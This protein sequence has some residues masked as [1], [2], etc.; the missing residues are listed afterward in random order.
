MQR[1]AAYA[2]AENRIDAIVAES[3]KRGKVR[4]DATDATADQRVAALRVLRERLGI[5]RDQALAA[6]LPTPREP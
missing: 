2:D 5:W 3:M 1:S 4:F 6:F